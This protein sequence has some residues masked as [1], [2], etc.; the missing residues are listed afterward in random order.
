MNTPVKDEVEAPK[1]KDAFELLTGKVGKITALIAA[2]TLVVTNLDTLVSKVQVLSSKLSPETTTPAEPTTRP[3]QQSCVEI[4]KVEFPQE[5]A[6]SEWND[7]FISVTGRNNCDRDLGLYLTF[8]HRVGAEPPRLVLRSPYAE[9]FA[10]CTGAASLSLPKCWDQMKPIPIVEGRGR[11]DAPLPPAF[12][13][14]EFETERLMFRLE[15]HDL[16]APNA[17]A[18]W[19]KTVEITIRDDTSGG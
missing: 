5:I 15:V 17:D 10:E 7:H 18:V 11:W 14:G 16:D 1:K 6:Y 2:L 9:T 8:T 13:L 19:K 3:L 4:Y 12:R